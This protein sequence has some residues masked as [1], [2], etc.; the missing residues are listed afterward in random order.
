MNK[1]KSWS[2]NVFDLVLFF[3]GDAWMRDK[4]AKGA[5]CWS[6]LLQQTGYALIPLTKCCESAPPLARRHVQLPPTLV[7]FISANFE[8]QQVNYRYDGE[9]E[10]M[11]TGPK[12]V[13][14]FEPDGIES[15]VYTNSEINT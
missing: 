12:E 9:E 3:R 5:K 2:K 15:S 8:T 7:I 6:L 1:Y 11:R 14:I 4:T 10:D 13:L